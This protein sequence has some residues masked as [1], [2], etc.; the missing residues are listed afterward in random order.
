MS[1]AA[2]AHR[3]GITPE[4]QARGA[5][6]ALLARLFA[7]APDSGLLTS[8]A[9]AAP[10]VVDANATP[11]SVDMNASS[12]CV[13][14]DP[15]NAEGHA[16]GLAE[17]WSELC[18]ASSAADPMSVREEFQALFIGVGRSEVSPYASHYLGP[19]SGR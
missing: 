2:L 3:G 1:D 12:L 6:Y 5:F 8:L 14:I 7:E 18:A 13:D 11:L 17:G 10:L 9:N 15:T 4:D 19:Q 16:R